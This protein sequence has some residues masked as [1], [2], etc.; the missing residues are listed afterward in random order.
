MQTLHALA[1]SIA[2]AL[3]DERDRIMVDNLTRLSRVPGRNIVAVVGLAHLDGIE[4][5]YAEQHPQ[6][7]VNA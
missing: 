1:P 5:L 7:G 3:V 4:R 2:N 6:P